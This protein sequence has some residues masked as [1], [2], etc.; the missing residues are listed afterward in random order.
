MGRLERRSAPARQTNAL[1]HAKIGIVDDR[2]L[3]LGS[4]NLNEHS[5][6]DDT[7]VTPSST[8]RP[9]ATATRHRLWAEHLELPLHAVVADPAKLVDEAWRPTASQQ[10]ARRQAGAPLTHPRPPARRLAPLTSPPRTDRASSST[11][12]TSPHTGPDRRCRLTRQQPGPEA[13][14]G[15]HRPRGLRE[16]VSTDAAAPNRLRHELV[17]RRTRA[18]AA[19]V[20]G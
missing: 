4:A 1:V 11:A 3:I 5:L 2:W 8:T 15:P 18:L 16:S 14:V 17:L 12:N 13:N 10:L 7:E 19:A 20:P 9:L 6:F